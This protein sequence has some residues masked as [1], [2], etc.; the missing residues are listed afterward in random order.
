MFEQGNDSARTTCNERL[1]MSQRNES[2]LGG[3]VLCGGQ[4]RRMGQ[5]KAWLPFGDERMLPRIV[6]LL[7]EVVEAVVVVAAPR[8]ELPPLG[9]NVTVA[10]DAREGR[11]PLQ[12]L[13]AG[14]SLCVDRFDAVYVTSCD[15]PLLQAAFVR[16]MFELLGDHAIAVPQVDGYH[17]P[18][19]AV[20]RPRVVDEIDRLLAADVLRVGE[21]F[22]AC[23]TRTVSR[24]ELIEVDCELST[25]RNL[26]Q[27]EDYRNALWAAG[28][29]S[30]DHPSGLNP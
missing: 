9:E 7:G 18:L 8:Q 21:L 12:G 16:R 2:R 13:A 25:L 17:H 3:V 23:P 30:L 11:G 5:S 22:E 28:L 14:L 27:P 20:Y 29:A 19:A 4:S 24:E 26:N 6:R 1:A 10:R 15:V